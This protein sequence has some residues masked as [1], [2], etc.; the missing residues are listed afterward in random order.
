VFAYGYAFGYALDAGALA[1]A[2]IEAMI[3]DATLVPP[4]TVH[5]PE[6]YVS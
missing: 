3:G 5:P 4:N 6:P 2:Y 1:S